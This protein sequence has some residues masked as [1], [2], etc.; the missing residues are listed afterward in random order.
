MT[1]LKLCD[2]DI[3]KWIEAQSCKRGYR[4]F[5]DGAIYDAQLQGMMLKAYCEGSR[6]QP[7]RV[8][9]TFNRDGI[10][11]AHCSCPVGGGGH[12][13][14]VAA[15]L[16]TYLN[17]PREFRDTE[18]LDTVLEKRT[19]DELIV[20]IK[21]MVA[22]QPELEMILETSSPTNG[23]CRTEVDIESYRRRAAAAFRCA[24]HRWGVE[25]DIADELNSVV[26]LGKDL[27]DRGDYISAAKV[28]QAVSQEVLSHYEMFSDEEGKLGSVVNN[29]VEALGQCLAG[30]GNDTAIREMILHA[31]FDIYRFDVDFGGVCLGDEV[32]DIILKHASPEEHCT[33][34]GWVRDVIPP[35][36]KDSWSDDWHRK[37]YGGFLLELE[38][39]TLDDEAYLRIC[40]ETGQLEDMVERLLSLGRVDE[41]IAEA[42]KVSDY[43][44]LQLAD[45]FVAHRQ[46]ETAEQL[47]VERTKTTKDTRILEWLL[48]RYKERDAFSAAL[49]LAQR[50][51][52]M[53]AEFS[54]YQEVRALAQKCGGWEKL[55]VQLLSEIARRKNYDLL[56][57]IYLDEDEIDRALETVKHIEV[58]SWGNNLQVEVARAAEKTRPNAATKMYLELADALISFRGRD[59]YR[60]A[61][62]FLSHARNLYLR[63]GQKETW[64]RYLLDLRERNRSLRALMEELSKARI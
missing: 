19:K 49:V 13:K 64:T 4:Y 24:H 3:R 17:R 10:S 7:Y 58:C 47:M 33:V 42:E 60:Q 48:T 45:I 15:L 14:H 51:F 61:C 54:K 34:A 18:E 63:L 9:A 56:T 38:K 53:R 46:S 39:K 44:M 50:I 5:E 41:A 21:Q 40:R 12:C 57:K 36:K 6:S 22:R 25:M 2:K 31:L 35:V 37:E 52:Q 27:A 1:T 29:C 23:K 30:V 26:E 32:P 59:N 20:V 16:F 55:R 62:V 28:Y 43:D 8:R 11:E